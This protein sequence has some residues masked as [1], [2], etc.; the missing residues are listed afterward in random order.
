[1]TDLSI[2]P[3]D[4]RS[5]LADFVASYDPG[6]ASA[7]EVGT[8]TDAGDGIAHVEGLPNVMANELVRF[9]DGTAG[10]ALNLEEDSPSPSATATSGASSTRSATRSTG[11]ARSPPTRSAPSS[12][13]RRA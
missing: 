11:A 5:A 4:I 8:V 6:K 12:C 2:S 9:E 1:M 10:L 13:R 3:D 7:T